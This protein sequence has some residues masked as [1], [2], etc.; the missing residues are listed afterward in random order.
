MDL[1]ILGAI[2]AP[3]GS[4]LGGVD[5]LLVGGA[6]A[7]VVGEDA[8]VE[9]DVV[10]EDVAGVG[11]AGGGVAGGGVAGA[12]GLEETVV[13]PVALVGLVAVEAFE[14]TVEGAA[15]EICDVTSPPHAASDKT[16]K[17]AIKPT[18][19]RFPIKLVSYL[20]IPIRCLVTTAQ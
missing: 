7:V 15:A 17:A 19:T 3:D 2:V 18:A 12:L 4:V 8:V 9:G 1:T 16:A 11:V 6:E 20:C 5:G 10:D 14:A 13:V